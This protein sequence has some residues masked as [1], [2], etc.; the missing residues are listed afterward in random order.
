M[1]QLLRRF[2][3]TFLLIILHITGIALYFAGYVVAGLYLLG[4]NCLF[5]FGVALS[6]TK[7]NPPLM[8][9]ITYGSSFLSG[10]IAD[11]HFG[12]TL[13]YFT[14]AMLLWFNSA[15]FRHVYL[16][17][18]GLLTHRWIEFV[19][20]FLGTLSFVLAPAVMQT[21]WPALLSNRSAYLKTPA[22][23][24]LSFALFGLVMLLYAF[25]K[26][27]YDYVQ[28]KPY[29]GRHP[30]M[31]GK[32]APNFQL[33]DEEGRLVDLYRDYKGKK[34]VLLFFTRGDWCPYCH[35][36]LRAYER[37][38]QLFNERGIEV[39]SINPDPEANNR[40][41]KEA[42]RLH[43][44][45]LYDPDLSTAELYGFFLPKPNPAAKAVSDLDKGVPLPAAILIDKEG[46]IRYISRSDKVDSLNPESILKIVETL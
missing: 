46:V 31:E 6:E 43:Y 36:M 17:R 32:E 13:P 35:I 27:Y 29:Y 37:A 7:Y 16:V 8:Y 30:V 33:P 42:L 44:R 3:L 26:H 14:F 2:P 24:L 28:S 40:Y 21:S 5:V 45:L 18:L 34:P 39:L 25:F 1:T 23:A 12:H 38:Y 4:L 19:S 10:L 20:W 15:M 11:L 41:K 22:A 9:A